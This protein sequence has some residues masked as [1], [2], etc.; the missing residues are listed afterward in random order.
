MTI[1]F[2]IDRIRVS[3]LILR[4]YSEIPNGATATN[5]KSTTITFISVIRFLSTTPVGISR[6]I[7]I[8]VRVTK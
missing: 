5:S 4:L 3:L 7:I 6:V 8:V 2:T 1:Y